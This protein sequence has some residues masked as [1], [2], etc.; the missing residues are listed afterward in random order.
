MDNKDEEVIVLQMNDEESPVVE[1]EEVMM[2]W[3]AYLR[4]LHLWFNGA[5]NLTKGSGFAGDHNEL[6]D[7]IY[8]AS[9][10]HTD[11]VLER[12]IGLT[13]NETVACPVGITARASEIMQQYPSPSNANATSIAC[14]GLALVKGYVA[15]LTSMY[16]DLDDKGLL[17]LGL[18]D[19]IMSHASEYEGF[20]YQL[21]QRVKTEE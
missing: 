7:M 19:L 9:A 14:V 10:E 4:T 17:T 1:L 5:H 2:Q 3:A 8:N 16:N 13:Q 11:T 6:Y 12:G 21:Q 15:G 18:D 20:A